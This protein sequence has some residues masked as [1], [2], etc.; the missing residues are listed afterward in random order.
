[1][2]EYMTGYSSY[3]PRRSMFTLALLQDTGWYLPFSHFTDSCVGIILIFL[4]PM[5]CIGGLT[6]VVGL[7]LKDVIQEH[8]HTGPPTLIMKVAH[9]MG[10]A[11]ED[12]I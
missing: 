8:H 2:N 3:D 10:F 11:K 12:Q 4:L 1:M 7:L 9:G 5:P 6:K